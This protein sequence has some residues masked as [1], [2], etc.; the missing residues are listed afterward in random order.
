MRR[1]RKSRRERLAHDRRRCRGA[2][3]ASMATT[4]SGLKQRLFV[5]SHPLVKVTVLRGGVDE[6][7]EAMQMKDA[8]AI[9]DAEAC[10]RS[11]SLQHVFR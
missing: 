1:G 5:S 6:D 9:K 2:V 3:G 11:G 7:P 10:L 8:E 4:P